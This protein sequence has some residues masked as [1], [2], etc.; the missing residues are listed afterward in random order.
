MVPTV[1]STSSGATYRNFYRI[2]PDL[3]R[4]ANPPYRAEHNGTEIHDPREDD[5]DVEQVDHHVREPGRDLDLE[6]STN[7]SAVR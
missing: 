4:K 6:G 3:F 1:A 2:F 7:Y 5:G